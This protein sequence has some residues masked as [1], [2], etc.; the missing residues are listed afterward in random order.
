MVG[1]GKAA[2]KEIAVASK[3]SQVTIFKYFTSKEGLVEAVM[4]EFITKRM[5]EYKTIACSDAPFRQR[6]AGLMALLTDNAK[7]FQG[8]YTAVLMRDHPQ[9]LERIMG[10]RRRLF[11]EIT[12]PFIAEGRAAGLID[13]AIADEMFLIY[14]EVVVAGVAA[15]LDLLEAILADRQRLDQ[16]M[17]LI[18]F[19][20]I[21]K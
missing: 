6:F 4:M 10:E 17:K 8:E 21:A 11:R 14:S 18:C 13:P 20:F 12:V 16:L 7:V 9:L 2:V 1:I 15:R 5:A 19:G 3:V